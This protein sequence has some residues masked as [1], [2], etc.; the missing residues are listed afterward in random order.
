MSSGLRTSLALAMRFTFSDLCL[1]IDLIALYKNAFALAY[2]SWAGPENLPPLEA[3]ALGCPVIATRIPGADEQ[4][5]DAAMLVEPGDPNDIAAGISQLKDNETRK[6]L[7][8]AGS[9]RARRWT[10]ED[11]VRGVF[12][13]IDGLE[14]IVRCWR[15]IPQNCIAGR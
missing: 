5:A 4:L 11:Y 3:F 12:R 2:V 1:A 13:V 8:A 15:P 14:P 7:I 6:R 10:S 9:L